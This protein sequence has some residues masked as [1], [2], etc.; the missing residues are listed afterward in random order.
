[1][2][3]KHFEAL[4]RALGET[5]PYGVLVARDDMAEAIANVCAD[6]NPLFNRERFLDAVTTYKDKAKGFD[7]SDKVEVVH[8]R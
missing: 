2:T 7:L 4:A 6:T 5:S 8:I 3:R 1:M